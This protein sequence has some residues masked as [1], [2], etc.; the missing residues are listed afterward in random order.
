VVLRA[1]LDRC[2]K[3]HPHWDLIPRLFF[4]CLSGGGIHTFFGRG[5]S[6]MFHTL[7]IIVARCVGITG[8]VVKV[9]KC[10][11]YCCLLYNISYTAFYTS[12][13]LNRKESC[14]VMPH[15]IML[16]PAYL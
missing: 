15:T 14:V 4:F 13:P 12:I 7:E 1:G 3:S 10:A 9:L 16:Y 2:G 5:A 8:N 6:C 11:H